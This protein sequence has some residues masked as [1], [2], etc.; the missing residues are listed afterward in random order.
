MRLFRVFLL[1]CTSHSTNTRSLQYFLQWFVTMPVSRQRMALP[2][3][4]GG[5]FLQPGR[6]VTADPDA[7]LRPS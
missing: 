7:S 5:S 3:V 4:S 6:Y 2:A 1:P